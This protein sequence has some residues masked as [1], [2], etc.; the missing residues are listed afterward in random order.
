MWDGILITF[1]IRDLLSTYYVPLL[2]LSTRSSQVCGQ[3]PSIQVYLQGAAR[4]MIPSEY[5]R[6]C[7]PT[8]LVPVNGFSS[9]HKYICEGVASVL[10]VRTALRSCW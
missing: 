6:E 7:H 1:N 8:L 4:R 9:N 3:A 5:L 2:L 10:T